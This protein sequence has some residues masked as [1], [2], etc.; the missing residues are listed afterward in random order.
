[1]TRDEL[2]TWLNEQIVS[3]QTYIM[4]EQIESLKKKYQRVC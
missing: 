4:V 1:M 3:A 2:I